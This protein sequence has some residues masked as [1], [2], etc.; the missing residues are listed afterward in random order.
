MRFTLLPLLCLTSSILALPVNEVKQTTLSTIEL[1]MQTVT[2]NLDSLTGNLK[3][4]QRY[5][6]H[7]VQQEVVMAG[8]RLTNTL[9]SDAKRIQDRSLQPLSLLD[10]ASLLSPINNLETATENASKA[11]IAAKDHIVKSTEQAL[12]SMLMPLS[13]NS[14]KI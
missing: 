8:E 1:S 12:S 9:L 6:E 2:S 5:N 14:R 13:P 11:W 10:Y 3:L 7:N 4:L